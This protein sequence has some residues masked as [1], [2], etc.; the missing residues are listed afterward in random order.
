M[1]KKAKELQKPL[2]ALVYGEPGTGKTTLIGTLPGPIAVLDFEGGA[3]IRLTDRDDILIAEITNSKELLEALQELNKMDVKSVVFDGFSVYLQA[4]L[5]EIVKQS[6]GKSGGPEFKHWNRLFREAK[7]VILTLRK[8]NAHLVFTALEKQDRNKD[9]EVILIRPDIPNGIRRYLRGLV[10]LEGRITIEDNKRKLVFNR[11]GI[12]ELKDRTG[13]LSI[14]EPDFGKI[15]GKIYGKSKNVV[16]EEEPKQE[17]QKQEQKQ[18]EPATDA[19]IRYIHKLVKDLVWGEEEYRDWLYDVFKKRSSK[20]L[21]KYEAS[22]AIELLKQKLE[23][24]QQQVEMSE[25]EIEELL[26]NPP[27]DDIDILL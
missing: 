20:E 1:F 16:I 19:Q 27:D 9:G 15:L 6:P 8:P 2:R 22:R 4:R 14:E 10:D 13:K 12:E 21:T 26:N 24:K 7:Q 25:D 11:P 5:E 23:Q 18:S 17:E 3:A